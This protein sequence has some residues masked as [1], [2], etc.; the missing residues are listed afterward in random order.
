[1]KRTVTTV[2]LGVCIFVAGA[3]YGQRRHPHLTAA[4]RAITTAWTQ[5]TAAQEA[6]EY[7]LGGHAQ[8]AKEA[9]DVAQKET[10][11][12]IEAAK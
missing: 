9:L 5:I 11:L 6:H 8:K 7:D 12:S 2:L 1:M 4:Q 10:R 3:A